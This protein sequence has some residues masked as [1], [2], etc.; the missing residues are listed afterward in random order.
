MRP[1]P[2]LAA[3]VLLLALPLTGCGDDAPDRY[4]GVV[5]DVR[6][7]LAEVLEADGGSAGL[8]P[9]LPVF[10]RLE[11][12]AP[13]DVADDWSIIVQRLSTLADALAAAGVDPATYDP[14]D[15]P[16]DVTAE[17]QEAIATGA[18]SVATEAVR[19]ALQ[20]V[21]QQSRDVCRAELE[22]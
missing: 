4:C 16:D 5:D 15:P 7:R 17:E 9:A 18:S 20:H 19:E 13:D 8:L 2:A 10:E 3:R 6:P 21:E 14:V 1:P 12:A 11:D 22:L